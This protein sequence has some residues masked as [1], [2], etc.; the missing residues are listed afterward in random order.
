MLFKSYLHRLLLDFGDIFATNIAGAEMLWVD[1]GGE[2]LLREKFFYHLEVRS[3]SRLMPK[4]QSLNLVLR[5][6]QLS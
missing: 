1:K 5:A 3:G 6:S 4:L 2:F